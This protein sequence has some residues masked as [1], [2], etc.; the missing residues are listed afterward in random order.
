MLFLFG[1]WRNFSQIA[2]EESRE[3]AVDADQP[4]K[5]P[6]AFTED[7]EPISPALYTPQV[8]RLEGKPLAHYAAFNPEGLSAYAF[9]YSDLGD[10]SDD[11]KC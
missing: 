6:E 2:A 1:H 11:C 9:M 8:R 4:L 3:Q 10:D 5:K 7:G